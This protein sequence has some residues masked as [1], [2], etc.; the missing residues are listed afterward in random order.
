MHRCKRL[1]SSRCHEG[2]IP[3]HDTKHAIIAHDK[4]SLHKVQL[5]TPRAELAPSARL[6]SSAGAGASTNVYRS[7]T[8][9]AGST[10]RYG[11]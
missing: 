1:R 11:C 4:C 7:G 9:E 10:C 2:V 5:D 6:L 3:V 8:S